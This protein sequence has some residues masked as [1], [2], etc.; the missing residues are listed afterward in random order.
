MILQRRLKKLRTEKKYSQLTLANIIGVNYRTI[1]NWEMGIAEPSNNDIVKI[2]KI[3]EVSIDFLLGKDIKTLELLNKKREFIL[4]E[5]SSNK[6]DKPEYHPIIENLIKMSQI[7]TKDKRDENDNKELIKL[8][9][10]IDNYLT[11][12]YINEIIDINPDSNTNTDLQLTMYN[13]LTN[14]K[15]KDKLTKIKIKKD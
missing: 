3:F 10:E 6:Q 12:L 9:I 4:T 5:I 8:N 11:D 1:S 14:L 13:Y 15:N 2:A 7:I